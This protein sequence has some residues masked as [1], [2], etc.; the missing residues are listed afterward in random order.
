MSRSLRAFFMSDIEGSNTHWVSQPRAMTDAVAT[1][2]ATVGAVVSA[3]GGELLKARGE[4]DSHFAVFGFATDAVLAGC[5]LQERLSEPVE[6]LE[7]QVRIAIHVGE[8]DAISD[9]YYGTTV[10]QTARLR[11][12]A[13]GG[14]TV[15][16]H[17][18]AMLAEPSLTDRV[19]LRSLGYHRI[20][21]FPHLEEV[22]QASWLGDDRSFP[23]LRIGENHGPALMAVAVVDICGATAAVGELNDPEVMALHREWTAWMRALGDAH[24]ATIVKTL[25]DGCVAAFEDPLDSL[26][27]TS[28]FQQAVAAQGFLIKAGIDV[29]RVELTD[30]EILGTVVYRAVGLERGAARGEIALSPLTRELAGISASEENPGPLDLSTDPASAP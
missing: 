28:A 19:A 24:H 22:F 6:A 12:A 3:H 9:D 23:P 7:I 2:D 10:N 25:G 13:H 1:L 29:G 15:V 16:S 27:F 18:T 17:V 11:A 5:A 30:G 8:V 20:R 26:A 4:G 14:Q 21:D